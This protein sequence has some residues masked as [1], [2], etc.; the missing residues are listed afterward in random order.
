MTVHFVLVCEG[1][2]DAGLLEHLRDLCVECG[3]DEATGS[4]PDLAR[5]PRPPSNLAGR[6]RAALALEPS[7]NLLFV[8][9]DADSPDETMRVEE[10][11]R[12][13]QGL[14]VRF[15][16]VIPVRETEAWLLLD[17]AAIRAVVENPSGRIP[18][19][20]PAPQDVERLAD[21]KRRLKEILDLA[22]EL[23]G[24]RLARHHRRF[25]HHRAM[26]LERLRRDGPIR[27]VPAWQRLVR[28]TGEALP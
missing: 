3:A 6:I 19:D 22:S 13:S 9:R 28:R 17:E 4:A 15:V 16:P 7:A 24:R 1:L 11:T 21:P 26:L 12:A 5:L 2:S 23:R 8:H 10:I 25:G 27:L 18:L 20:L 14:Q